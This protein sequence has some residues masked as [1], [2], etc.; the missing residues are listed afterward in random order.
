M[1]YLIG[2]QRAVIS[3]YRLIKISREELIYLTFSSASGNSSNLAGSIGSPVFLST[4]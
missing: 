4:P 1:F 3:E 2:I